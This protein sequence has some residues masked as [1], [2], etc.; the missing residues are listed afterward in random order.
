MIYV[1][2]KTKKNVKNFH[3]KIIIFEAVKY[4]CTLHGRGCVMIEPRHEKPVFAY[5]KAKAQ[6]AQLVRVS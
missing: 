1:L 3:Q 2:S 5:A 6:T 4:Y